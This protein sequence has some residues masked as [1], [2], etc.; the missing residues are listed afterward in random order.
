MAYGYC[1]SIDAMTGSRFTASDTEYAEPAFSSDRRTLTVK[2]VRWDTIDFLHGISEQ[3]LRAINTPTNKQ[4]I[5]GRVK[6]WF[7]MAQDIKGIPFK[8]EEFWRTLVLD[9][10]V[11]GVRDEAPKSWYKM[12]IEDLTNSINKPGSEKADEYLTNLVF[13]R[14]RQFAVSR[15]G[16]Y[17]MVPIHTEPADSLCILHGCDVPVVLRPKGEKWEWIGECYGFGLMDGEICLAE[18]WKDMVESVDI[19]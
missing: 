15:K 3:T 10:W 8:E 2:G 1:M 18:S 17:L 9:S 14:L 16:A 4:A 5:V 19:I 11:E 12:T 7:A 13:S 6:E